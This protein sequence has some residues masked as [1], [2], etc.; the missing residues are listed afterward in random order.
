MLK[1]PMLICHIY[2]I[3]RVG[4]RWVTSE[5]LKIISA[6]LGEKSKA[7]CVDRVANNYH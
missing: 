5:L 1:A 4:D 2:A 7:S 3:G 6:T